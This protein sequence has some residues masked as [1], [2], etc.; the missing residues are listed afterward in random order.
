MAISENF[1]KL[2]IRIP[3]PVGRLDVSTEIR[4][5]AWKAPSL[6]LSCVR[7]SRQWHRNGGLLIIGKTG[8]ASI[9]T[10]Q[11]VQRPGRFSQ[12]NFSRKSIYR[13]PS[14]IGSLHDK[15]SSPDPGDYIT[16]SLEVIGFL[17]TKHRALCRS[18]NAEEFQQPC[19][20]VFTHL[21]KK[22]KACL[23]YFCI[24]NIGLI[25]NRTSWV[26]NNAIFAHPPSSTLILLTY[27]LQN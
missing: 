7:R 16:P 14:T 22:A 13:F 12:K 21:N 18:V 1:G 8:Y 2:V 25:K 19:S 15:R 10:S 5:P 9:K 6:L 26:E 23:I 27:G 3:L 17:V 24:D 11:L 4:F 20:R